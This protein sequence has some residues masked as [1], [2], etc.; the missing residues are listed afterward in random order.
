M[1]IQFPPMIHINKNSS[2]PLH[3]QIKKKL[4]ENIENGK[5]LPN[6]RIIP[7]I[8][9]AKKLNVSRMTVN[10]II[11]ELVRE[12]LVYRIQGKGTF[13]TQRKIDQWF[14]RIT[15]FN[16]D[17]FARSL[18]PRTSVLEK[19]VL[20]APKEVQTSL[21]LLPKEKVI[22]IKRLRYANNDPIMLESR[23]L[24]YKL[25]KQIL[26]ESL[27]KESVHDLLIYKYKLPLTKVNQYLEAINIQGTD[28]KLLGVEPGEPGFLLC[29]T[30][31]TGESPVTWVRYTYR[32]DK[33]R[34]YAE[35]IPTES[36]NH[37]SMLQK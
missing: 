30:T 15:S 32:G 8:E 22:F 29:R 37:H 27:E 18:I 3:I 25:C 16:R 14:F 4:K 34:F 36:A 24:N 35:F 1:S 2:I 11:N 9:F 19:E 28:A 33:Y 12:G 7:E 26:K 21:N 6:G 31:F 5:Y 10:K 20:T 13:V 23:Y 17:M